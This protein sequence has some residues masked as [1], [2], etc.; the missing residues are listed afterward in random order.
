MSDADFPHEPVSRHVKRDP[1]G[2]RRRILEAATEE[3]ARGGLGGARVDRIARGAGAN[4]RMI[5]YYFGNKE[6]LF[7]AVLEHAYLAL[8]EAERALR[9]DELPPEAAMRALIAFIWQ[10]Y[11]DHPELITL[12]NSENLHEGR[13]LQNS[14][15]V[16]ELL[17]PTVQLIA[18]VLDRGVAAGTFRRGIDPVQ[19]Y[20][21]VASL[22]YF[23]L[24]NQHT[25][26]AVL[27][28]DTRS[29]QALAD[30]LRHNTELVMTYLQASGAADA[31]R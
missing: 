31:L 14:P 24:S 26:R 28:I 19:L 29:A 12:V 10:Y 6:G 17:A 2:T 7:R 4:E 25:L 18:R 16:G 30:H 15:R 3:F 8:V 13:H 23:H 22:G 27:G 1:E 9:L 21:S 5:Y 20:I 11:V